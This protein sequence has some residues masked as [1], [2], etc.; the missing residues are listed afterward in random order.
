MSDHA[1][2]R[3]ALAT[4]ERA[5]H[6]RPGQPVTL[7]EVYTAKSHRAALDPE[8]ALVVGNRGMGKSFWAHALLNPEIR[9]HAAKE[10]RF[11]TL[12]ATE[13]V[14]GFNGSDRLDGIAP[15][16][17]M[18]AEADTGKDERILW[19][20][21]LARVAAPY[22][23]LVLPDR[24][25]DIVAWVQ[26][27]AER[28]ARLFTRA[29]DV[30]MSQGKR[31]ILVF[32][33][34]DLLSSD[35]QTGRRRLQG[36]LQLAL[37]AL[38]FRAIRTKIFLRLDQFHDPHLFL[39][40]DGSK[41]RNPVDLRWADEDLYRLL[42]HRLRNCPAFARLQASQDGHP[43]ARS[44]LVRFLAGTYMGSGATRGFVE[45]WLPTHLADAFGQISPRTFLTAWREAARHGACPADTAVDHHGVLEGVRKASADRLAEIEQDYPW[46]P[47]ALTPLRGQSVPLPQAELLHLWQRQ[48]TFAKVI[49]LAQK[50]GRLILIGKDAEPSTPE[51]ALLN[52][53]KFIGV[54]ELRRNG[55][56]DMPDIFRVQAGIKRRGGVK[57]PRR[58]SATAS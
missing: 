28:I 49:D 47:I 48:N 16:A 51:A 17:D 1:E 25:R 11:P 10:F 2:I 30:L 26:A 39:F 21:V 36:L 14:V 38:S 23:G 32:D 24:Y 6:H 52:A 20:A 54:L 8:R 35:G 56:V 18:V 15:T 41:V 57:P 9:A 5:E 45:T 43:D 50:Q 46:V 4:L 13:V 44:R 34:L 33:A 7:A 3:A 31:L 27:D 29:D 12:E 22:C 55:K 37:S 53:L 19:Q 40:P 58:G 42:F